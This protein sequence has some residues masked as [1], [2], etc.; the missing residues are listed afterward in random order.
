MKRKLRC[1]RNGEDMGGR[2]EKGVNVVCR[3]NGIGSRTRISESVY[4]LSPD[5]TRTSQRAGLAGSGA[6]F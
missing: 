6:V 1:R 3:A 4:S 5:H 2:E